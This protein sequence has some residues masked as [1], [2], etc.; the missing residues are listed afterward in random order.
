MPV[1]RCLCLNAFVSLPVCVSTCCVAV[2]LPVRHTQL[3]SLPLCTV[4]F[5]L[6]RS[7]FLYVALTGFKS[8]CSVCHCPCLTPYVRSTSTRLPSSPTRAGRWPSSPTRQRPSRQGSPGFRRTGSPYRAQDSEPVA[9]LAAP[10]QLL[11]D[12]SKSALLGDTAISVALASV[13]ASIITAL[14]VSLASVSASILTAL[15]VALA[16]VSASIITAVYAALVSAS[17]AARSLPAS[18][19]T[20]FNKNSLLQSSHAML[21]P[22]GLMF[23]PQ[24]LMF[25]LQELIRKP[26]DEPK[27]LMAATVAVPT[28]Y[29]AFS[30][31]SASRLS[32]LECSRLMTFFDR[33][34]RS[35]SPTLRAFWTP[36]SGHCCALADA[37]R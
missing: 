28:G 22:Q 32:G 30:F 34:I 23:V 16:S 7:C 37:V 35:P 4:C 12:I 11:A 15:S 20:S 8:H 24:E 5:S 1:C 33:F 10:S 36:S 27:L 31:E 3:V 14:S 18:H 26:V 25:V 9:K 13:S 29:P 2:S 17:G 19:Q 6:A 21:V